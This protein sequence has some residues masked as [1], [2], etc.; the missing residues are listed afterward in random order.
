M[1]S[2]PSANAH[3]MTQRIEY[4]VLSGAVSAPI[5]SYASSPSAGTKSGG[6][7]ELT[8][9]F[10]S[11]NWELSVASIG[12][13]CQCMQGGG[14]YKRQ[15]CWNAAKEALSGS[16]VVFKIGNQGGLPL[17]FTPWFTTSFSI[18]VPCVKYNAKNGYF[19]IGIGG[20]SPSTFC[21]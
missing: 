19:E 16:I 11:A 1:P 13:S 9:K 4:A 12:P 21:A 3:A 2:P 14:Q 5:A 10:L 15:C 20:G 6:F 8:L 18:F 17:S 7:A